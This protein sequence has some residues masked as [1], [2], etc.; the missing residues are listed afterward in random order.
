MQVQN[1]NPNNVNTT[2]RYQLTVELTQDPEEGNSRNDLVANSTAI[3]A[4]GSH[5]GHI[6]ASNDFDWYKLTRPSTPNANSLV[7]IDCTADPAAPYSLTLQYWAQTAQTCDHT[8]TSNTVALN[9]G[10]PCADTDKCLQLLIQRPDP[11][12]AHG[13]PQVG[14]RAPNKLH[15]QLPILNATNVWTRV[16]SNP[17]T[18]LPIA[19]YDNEPGGNPYAIHV[20]VQQRAGRGRRKAHRRTIRSS[21]VR[22]ST[23]PIL[24]TFIR[25]IAATVRR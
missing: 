2:D 21:V 5:T 17:S 3:T 7:L 15:M 1:G 23:T 19:G 18:T 11:D 6:V 25:T 8:S 16:A 4:N 12:D 10:S 24:G 20:H 22:R 13:D 9:G 14:G